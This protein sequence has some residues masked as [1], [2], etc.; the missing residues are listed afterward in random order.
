M[1]KMWNKREEAYD[2]AKM[3]LKEAPDNEEAQ[4]LLDWADRKA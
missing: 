2:I 4:A 1:Y 3:A